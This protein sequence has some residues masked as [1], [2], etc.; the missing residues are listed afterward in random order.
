MRGK[1]VNSTSGLWLRKGL[2]VIQFAVSLLLIIGSLLIYKQINYLQGKKLGYDKE[3]LL[4]LPIDN[5]IRTSLTSFKHTLVNSPF[6]SSATA[7]TESPHDI[8]G[9]YGLQSGWDTGERK[10]VKAM[11]IDKDFVETMGLQ[12][13]SGSNYTSLPDSQEYYQFLVNQQTLKLM[14]WTETDVVGKAIDL[15]GRQGYIKGVVKDF[16]L[17]SLHNPIEPLVLFSGNYPRTLL[18]KLEA[19]D[20]SKALEH[21]ESSWAEWAPHRPFS[22]EFLD[23]AYAQLYKNEQTMGSITAIFAGLAIFIAALGLFGLAAFSTVQRF[24][25]IGIRK[26]LGASVGSIIRLLSNEFLRLIIIAIVISVPLSWYL[27]SQW[28]SNFSYRIEF[29]WEMVIISCVAIYSLAA[30]IVGIQAYQ[31]ASTNPASILKDE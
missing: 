8:G 10:L 18:V 14:D 26:V 2:L 23:Q 7:C 31:A 9:G 11:S 30:L 5:K 13:I 25:E 12:I 3:H 17:T 29:G 24:K 21:L 28:L 15:N 27:L 22:Y 20:V 6:V 19:G 1:F 16:H 4:L